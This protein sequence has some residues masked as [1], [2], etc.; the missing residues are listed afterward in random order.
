[1]TPS[2]LFRPALSLS[3]TAS[4]LL[5][6]SALAARVTIPGTSTS[7]DV[8]TGFVVMPKSVIES[9][10]SR[11]STP[12]STVYSTPGPQWDVNIAF[13]LRSTAL[14]AG[15]LA[16]VQA[17]LERSIQ[18]TPGFRWVSHGIVKS[19]SRDWIDLRFWVN[20][21]DQPIYN[22]LRVTREGQG[23]LIVTANAT[24]AQYAKYGKTLDDAMNGL[25]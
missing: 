16:P 11:G 2:P 19:G 21:A 17:G 9:K 4:L 25:K 23:A 6:P 12:P 8:P 1:M 24:R 22:H 18:G 20:G 15:S 14:P 10:Y 7:L 5:L 13:V 3:L